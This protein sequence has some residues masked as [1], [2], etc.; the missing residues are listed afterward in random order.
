MVP[1]RPRAKVHYILPAVENLAAI[2]FVDAEV[3]IRNSLSAGKF[4]AAF[5]CNAYTR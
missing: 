5:Y 3:N 1:P 4:T 2:V